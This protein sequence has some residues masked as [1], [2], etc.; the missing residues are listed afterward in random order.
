MCR[1]C[2]SSHELLQRRRGDCGFLQTECSFLPPVNYILSVSCT[3]E[4]KECFAQK[5]GIVFADTLQ[6]VVSSLAHSVVYS[7]CM[8]T[9]AYTQCVECGYMHRVWRVGVRTMNRCGGSCFVAACCITPPPPPPPPLG[10]SCTAAL[11][12][13]RHRYTSQLPSSRVL[14]T[15]LQ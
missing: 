9:A 6:S 10:A 11:P 15:F 14:S 7:L 5:A 4:C 2:S 1:K 13:H 3:L 8:N 12:G